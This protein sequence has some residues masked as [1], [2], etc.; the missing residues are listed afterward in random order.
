[1]FVF[2]R[3]FGFDFLHAAGCARFLNVV[4]NLG[5][6]SLF[7]AGGHVLWQLACMM[8]VANVG[9]SWFGTR[10]ALSRGSRFV[11]IVFL[12]VVVVLI[13]KTAWDAW[14]KTR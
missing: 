5:A 3:L 9:G 7:A 12:S 13:A 8:A 6:V 1:M 4:T 2:I 11:R 10:L 14:L